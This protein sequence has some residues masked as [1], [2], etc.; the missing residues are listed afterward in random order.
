[1]SISLCFIRILLL[2]PEG[3]LRIAFFF[4][5][6]KNGNTL[7]LCRLMHSL[8]LFFFSVF[9]IKG[10]FIT[11]ECSIKQIQSIMIEMDWAEAV[12]LLNARTIDRSR[13]RVMVEEIKRMVVDDPREISI[14]AISRSRNKVS[15]ALAAYGRSTL[16]LQY[17]WAQV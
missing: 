14:T 6:K 9:S 10:A 4:P 13:V 12:M 3:S 5:F 2:K 8:R 17:S 15:H 1:M 16:V 11:S 7:D